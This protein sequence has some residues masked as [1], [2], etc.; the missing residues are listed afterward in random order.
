MAAV[1]V[2]VDQRWSPGRLVAAL[3][4]A[5]PP[6]ATWPFERYADLAGLLG[7]TWRLRAEAP[8][9]VVERLVSWLVRRPAQGVAVALVTVGA[10]TGLALLLGPPA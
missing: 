5:V 6:F 7:R 10:L 9:G 8:V 2:G 1:V 3:A 4:A